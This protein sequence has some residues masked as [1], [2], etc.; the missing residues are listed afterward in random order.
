MTTKFSAFTASTPVA[1]DQV[2]GLKSGGMARY[3][4]TAINTLIAAMTKTLTN[5]TFD[6]AGAGNSLSINGVAA[7]ANTGTGAVARASSPVFVTPS[8]GNAAATT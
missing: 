2:V 5:T 3:T 6:T 8:L 4:F 1:A 7:S